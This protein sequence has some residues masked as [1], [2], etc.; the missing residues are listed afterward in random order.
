MSQHRFLPEHVRIIHHSHCTVQGFFG[1]PE[2]FFESFANLYRGAAKV[3]RKQT[4]EEV[5]FPTISDG[6]RTMKFVEAVVKSHNQ[7]NV[8]ISL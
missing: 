4:L 1:L 8:W 7:G 6:V 5:E 3:I 2:G